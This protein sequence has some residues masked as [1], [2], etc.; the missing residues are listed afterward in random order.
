MET[1]SI[2]SHYV[3]WRGTVSNVTK[4]WFHDVI[5][6]LSIFNGSVFLGSS[7]EYLGNLPPVSVEDFQIFVDTRTAPTRCDLVFH[8][9]IGNELT[10]SFE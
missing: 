7:F 9:G 1:E 8:M 3:A 2:S 4:E 10:V 6:T 5:V